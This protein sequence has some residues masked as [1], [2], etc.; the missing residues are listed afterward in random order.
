[1]LFMHLQITT[2]LALLKFLYSLLLIFDITLQDC[3]DK[4]PWFVYLFSAFPP[5]HLSLCF[6]K[7]WMLVII[8]NKECEEGTYVE[9]TIRSNVNGVISD[10]LQK[11]TY[12]CFYWRAYLHTLQWSLFYIPVHDDEV[13]YL[14]CEPH[15]YLF[16]INNNEL[17]VTDLYFLFKIK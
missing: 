17:W 2:I 14:M 9:S 5:V 4:N 1:M 7:W 8:F 13:L 11:F 10:P 15:D 3:N 12:R 6:T 16:S